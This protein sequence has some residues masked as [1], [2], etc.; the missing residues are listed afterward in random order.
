VALAER[1][2]ERR[3]DDVARAQPEHVELHDAAHG[4][5]ALREGA[6]AVLLAVRQRRVDLGEERGR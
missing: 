2:R 3:L 4:R 1:D 5:G 6:L